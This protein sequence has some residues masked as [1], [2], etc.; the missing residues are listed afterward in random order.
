MTTN[1]Q[2]R[3][4]EKFPDGLYTQLQYTSR[5][6]DNR[7]DD[8]DNKDD[9]I[10]AFIAQEFELAAQEVEKEK[11]TKW[12][13]FDN[14]SESCAMTHNDALEVAADI[15]RNRGREIQ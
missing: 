8:W 3:F 14:N 15:I 1:L 9:N 4:E 12:N 5:T 7:K 6:G 10:L 13:R 2:R 11:K